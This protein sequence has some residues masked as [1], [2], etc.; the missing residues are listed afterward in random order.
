[1]K[2]F[3]VIDTTTSREISADK[4]E[5]IA[6]DYGLMEMDIDQF[7]ISEDGNL[8]LVDDCGNSTYVDAEKY[9]LMPVSKGKYP[10]LEY[11]EALL[12]G[13]LHHQ[14][15]EAFTESFWQPQA[16]L[17]A[18]FP[19]TWPNTAGGFSKPGMMSGQAFTTEITTVLR[20]YVYDTK[21]EYYG[22]FFGNKP[23]YL[24]DNAPLVFF[25]DLKNRQMKSKYEAE[26]TY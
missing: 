9:K 20:V 7:C 12:L 5:Q 25:E 6:K 24:V 23:A 26:K 8:L 22:V 19:Q 2:T 18:M 3:K 13:N 11:F 4:T 17:V 21:E 10:D 15:P 1:M 16:E 14:H